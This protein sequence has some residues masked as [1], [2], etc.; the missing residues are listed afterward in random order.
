VATPEFVPEI[1][2]GALAE[3]DEYRCFAVDLPIDGDR[4]LTGYEVFPGNEAIVHHVI[5]MPV[6]LDETG[7]GGGRTNAEIIDELS[8]D[9]RGGWP[10]FEGAGA[11]VSFDGEIIT[12]APGQ[13]AVEYPGGAGLR[14][15]AN[16]KMVFQI[17]YNLVDPTT[18]GQSD[19]TEV[20]LRLEESARE[21]FIVLPDLFLAGE[22]SVDAI[23]PGESDAVVRT[24]LPIEWMLDLPVTLEILAVLPHMHERGRSMSVSFERTDGTST[25]VAEV[26]RWDFEWQ[27]MY[28]YEQPIPFTRDDRLITECVYDTSSDTEPIQ[29]GWG[30]Q[31]EMCLPGLL[32]SLKL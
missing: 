31:N 23:P 4:Y 9:G 20:A 12:W 1:V 18:R 7:R 5:G 28:I 27:R 10:C 3:F 16:T 15:G 17:H 26:P 30:T 24:E 11:G 8:A 29:P 2:G 25:C 21:A 13:G 14:V 22:A 6:D 19:S 32:V